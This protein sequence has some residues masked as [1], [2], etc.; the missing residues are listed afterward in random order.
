MNYHSF[1]FQEIGDEI[2]ISVSLKDLKS[3][4]NQENYMIIRSFMLKRAIF[5]LSKDLKATPSSRMGREEEYY[6]MDVISLMG[7]IT[8]PVWLN[9]KFLDHINF[10]KKLPLTLFKYKMDTG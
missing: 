4:L 6:F 7:G 9:M 2:A 10:S 1:K 8:L 5:F 3:D